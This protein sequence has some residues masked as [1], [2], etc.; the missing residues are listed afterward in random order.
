MTRKVGDKAEPGDVLLR[1]RTVEL[2]DNV[3]RVLLLADYQHRT[4][5]ARF[6]LPIERL[7]DPRVPEQDQVALLEV[8]VLDTSHMVPLETLE[9][10]VV[11][12]SCIFSMSSGRFSSCHA[13]I[14]MSSSVEI[15]KSCLGAKYVA[16]TISKGRRGWMP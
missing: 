4:N 12:V 16:S 1:L 3:G 2:R 8:E 11:T 15:P 7:F 13:R 9:G 6:S 14:A 10:L 5:V